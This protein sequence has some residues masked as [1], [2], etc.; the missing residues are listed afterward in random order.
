MSESIYTDAEILISTQVAY[1]D[2]DTKKYKNVGDAIAE[3]E[4]NP[5]GRFER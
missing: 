4:R 1:L 2:I 5:T 3:N